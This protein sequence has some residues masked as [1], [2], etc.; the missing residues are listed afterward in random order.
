MLVDD[1][2]TTGAT[3]HLAAEALVKAGAKSVVSLTVFR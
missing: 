1:I 3:L 2:Y